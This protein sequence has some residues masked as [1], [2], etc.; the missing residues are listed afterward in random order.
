MY[1]LLIADDEP[2]ERKALRKILSENIP[3]ISRIED[4]H[5]GQSALEK[6]RRI[7]PDLIILDIKMPR[8]NGLEAARKIKIFHP[9]CR[10]ILLSGYT[11]FN[12][13][14]E[15]VNIGVDDFLVKPVPDEDLIDSVRNL[16]ESLE[17][18][19]QQ[20]YDNGINTEKMNH[21]YSCLE[22]EFITTLPFQ[23]IREPYLSNHLETLDIDY[24]YSIGIILSCKQQAK[25][26]EQDFEKLRNI[27]I[28]H[29]LPN[30]VILQKIDNLIYVIVFLPQFIQNP[31][32][33]KN[34]NNLI[35]EIAAGLSETFHIGAG[36]IKS[37]PSEIFDSFNEAR[38][39]LSSENIVSLFRHDV[40]N[41]KTISTVDKEEQLIDSILTGDTESSLALLSEV[42]QIIDTSYRNY[43]DFK[44]RVYE[45]LLVLSR[46]VRRELAIKDNLIYHIQLDECSSRDE[47]KTYLTQEVHK[48]LHKVNIFLASSNITWK[49][50]IINYLEKHL[51]ETV[52]LHDL[53]DI[54][55]LST[56][57]LSRM[58]KKEFGMNCISYVNYL[59]IKE[60]KRLLLKSDL[61]IKEIAYT[62]GYNDANYFARV[63]K[64]EIGI[65]ASQYKNNT[66]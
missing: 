18:Q 30:R 39:A 50:K 8:L 24:I 38:R 29:F 49:Q 36:T 25:I 63:F 37:N 61:S 28:S 44:I 48:L 16:T 33:R 35:N 17:K 45:M 65:T 1:T 66:Y 7:L 40:S 41:E 20:N 15:A 56:S 46:R 51:H 23:Q 26:N 12:Y 59:K 47:V 43:P 54:A 11:Y 55:C 52:T 60:A 58:F 64:K 42:Y 3:E 62:L 5:D 6:A 32:L 13:A 10:I 57:Y 19:K 9:T 31:Q 53:A 14:K 27:M 22:N 2:L 21:I 4:S 34:L